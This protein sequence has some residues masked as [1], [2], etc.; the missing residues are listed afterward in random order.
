MVGTSHARSKGRIA[1]LIFSDGPGG[2]ERVVANVATALQS[3]GVETV[4]FL[5]FNGEG[6]L[7]SQLAGSGV[8][9]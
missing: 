1:Q 7:A 6:W 2:A 5:P 4:V 8:E 9:V 3:S